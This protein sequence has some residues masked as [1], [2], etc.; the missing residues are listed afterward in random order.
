ML[1][2]RRLQTFPRPIERVLCPSS[3]GSTYLGVF[4]TPAKEDGIEM[5]EGVF[6]VAV[7]A[8]ADLAE[9]EDAAVADALN[10]RRRRRVEEKERKR[11][12]RI[13][14]I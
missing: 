13:K 14:S 6:L 4:V 7:A 8:A 2:V 1:K 5:V 11:R 9:D 3:C 10:R 12:L